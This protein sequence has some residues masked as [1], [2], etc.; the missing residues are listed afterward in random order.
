MIKAIVYTSN[1][2]YTAGYA[3]LLGEKT[4]LPVC[5][6]GE[7]K[8]KVPAGEEIIYLGWLMAGMIKGCKPA[9]KRYRVRMVCGVGMGGTGTQLAEVRKAAGL[10]A[11]VPLFTLQGG[12]DMQKL[13]GI[14]RFMMTVMAKTLGKK[15]SEK[16]NRTPD[17]EAMLEMLLHGGSYVSEENLKDVLAWYQTSAEK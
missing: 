15:L 17:E 8:E 2:G 5:S 16:E 13:H 6:L 14:Y 7:A 3:R 10:P 9:V 4:G 1:T 11:S 12:F